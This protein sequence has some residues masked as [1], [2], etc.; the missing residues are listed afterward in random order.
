MLR[1]LT[2]KLLYGLLTIVLASA[3]IFLVIRIIV[4][5]DAVCSTGLCSRL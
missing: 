2:E 4:S 5:A 3:L 1:V